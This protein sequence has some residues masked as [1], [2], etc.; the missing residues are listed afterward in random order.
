ML[1]KYNLIM[2]VTGTLLSL[3]NMEKKVITSHYD[4]HINTFIPSVYGESK[5]YYDKRSYIKICEG[6][7]Y[8]NTIIREIDD[9][10]VGV[11]DGTKR[12]VLV[13][14]MSIKAI[15]EFKAKSNIRNRYDYF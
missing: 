4:I 2:G 11:R 12:A 10:L 8:Y 5:F 3:S 15:D 14:F 13:F 9:N 7:G 1:N 6:E